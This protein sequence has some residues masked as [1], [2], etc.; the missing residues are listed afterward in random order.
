MGFFNKLKETHG[1]K[2]IE[3]L[4]NLE[5]ELIKLQN[6]IKSE[7]IAIIGT[8]GRLKGLPLIYTT[9][10]ENILKSFSARIIE[11]LKTIEN[12]STERNFRDLTINFEDTSILFLKP[13]MKDISFLAIFFDKDD[14]MVLK[15]F[16]YNNERILKE[17]FHE[18]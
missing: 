9:D 14:I 17:L 12:L 11:I 2:P 13:I 8:G 7:F 18:T 10:D 3:S 4:K 1:K 5:D 15:Q 16:I 6:R